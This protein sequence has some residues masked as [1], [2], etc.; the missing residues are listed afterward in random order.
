MPDHQW[1]FTLHMFVFVFHS[2]QTATLGTPNALLLFKRGPF[3][4]PSVLSVRCY[5]FRLGLGCFL[6]TIGLCGSGGGGGCCC[7]WLVFAIAHLGVFALC[8]L[9]FIVFIVTLAALFFKILAA[10]I[11]GFVDFLG[12]ACFRHLRVAICLIYHIGFRFFEFLLQRSLHLCF[13]G[14]VAGSI[15]VQRVC[16]GLVRRIFSGRRFFRIPR[17]KMCQCKQLS[18]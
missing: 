12:F 11:A 5:R 18:R 8:A 4:I 7:G 6:L 16:L 14:A 2:Q 10:V 15:V 9:F 3:S 1:S 17:Q 13:F